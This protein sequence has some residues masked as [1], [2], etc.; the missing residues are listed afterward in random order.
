MADFARFPL[1][2]GLNDKI[3]RTI[4]ANKMKLSCHDVIYNIWVHEKK[5][6]KE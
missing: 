3:L 1:K 2:I 5:H 6:P 4:L